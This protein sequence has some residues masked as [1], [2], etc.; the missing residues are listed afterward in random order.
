MI[1]PDK[2][3]TVK[4]YTMSGELFTRGFPASGGP[5]NCS[6]ACC[7]GGVFVD[8]R[9]RDV[10]MAHKTLITGHMD[11]TQSVDPANWFEPEE[12]DDEDFPSGRCVG[13][14]V[15]N[16][17]CAFLDKSGRCSLQ[18]AAL[19]SGLHK[20][21][22]KPLFCILYPIEIGNGVVSFDDMLQE[23]ESCCT[24]SATFAMPIFQGC[25]EELIHLVGEDGFA[26]MEAHYA[27]LQGQGAQP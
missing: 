7:E 21:A 27:G 12:H 9:E 13:T 8:L 23:E 14:R 26:L 1:A 5:C 6:S 17:K 10:I 20:W 2:S 11:E 18:V 15:L 4:E 3:L 16:D 19:G 24:A 22:L 25:R